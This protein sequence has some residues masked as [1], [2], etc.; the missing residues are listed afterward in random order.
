MMPPANSSP[1]VANSARSVLLYGYGNPGRQDDGLGVAFVEQLETWAAVEKISG[2]AC[3]T[4]YQLNAED[5]LAVSAHDVVVFVDATQAGP[6]PFSF[7]RIAPQA[8]I[9]FSTHAMTP[10]SVLALGVELYGKQPL[11]WLLT[12]RGFAWEPNAALT[13]AAQA[14]LAAALV[15][16]KDWLRAPPARA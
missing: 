6:E 8:T 9:A 5:A 7:R 16:L 2:L 10:E 11:A 13:A 1:S 14:N 15:F 3:D 12:I 4:N